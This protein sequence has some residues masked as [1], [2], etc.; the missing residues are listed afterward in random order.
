MSV[1]A[2][3]TRV[4]MPEVGEGVGYGMTYRIPYKGT[5]MATVNIGYADGLSRL[6]SNNMDVLVHGKRCQQVGKMHGPVHVRSRRAGC[7]YAPRGN[8]VPLSEGDVV[9]VLGRD[10]QEEIAA[11]EMADRR[12][13]INYERSPATSACVWKSCMSEAR[14]QARRTRAKKPRPSLLDGRAGWQ[15]C[16]FRGMSIREPREVRLESRPCSETAS[17]A[18][19]ARRGRTSSSVSAI[20]MPASCS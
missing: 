10:G 4:T 12:H 18:P 19:W 20:P 8:A 6:L 2:R 1:K 15:S 9:T 13:T 3:I 11:D 14:P 7:P 16:R 17:G 5:Q